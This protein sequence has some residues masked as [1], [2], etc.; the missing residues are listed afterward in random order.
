MASSR[1]FIK[2]LPPTFTDVEFRKHFSQN[3]EITDAK[4]FPNRRIGYIG[5]K[6]PEDA[7]KAVKYFNKTFIRM[8]RIGVELARPPAEGQPRIGDGSERPTARRESLEKDKPEG[9]KERRLSAGEVAEKQDPKLKEF[10]EVM[11]PKS[12]KRAWEDDVA[13][14]TE[15][16]TVQEGNTTINVAA[17]E[18]QSDD[19]YE[20]VP[21]QTKKL[22]KDAAPAEETDRPAE[23]QPTDDNEQDGDNEVTEA[24]AG[25]TQSQQPALSDADWARSRTSRLLGLLDDDEGGT[26]G[27]AQQDR[28][29]SSSDGGAEVQKGESKSAP[30]EDPA[31]SM[32]TPPSDTNEIDA[33]FKTLDGDT[34]AVRSSMR[35]FV[36]NLPYDVKNEDLQAA[37][38]R[39]GHLEEVCLYPLIHINF[40]MN[41]LI[42]TAYA[43]AFDV[44]LGEHFSRCFSCLNQHGWNTILA[45]HSEKCR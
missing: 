14:A 28:E 36:R 43:S 29:D 37:F 40:V 26:V 44:N 21:R 4:I 27:E 35:L 2:G 25:G 15:E 6:T 24:T 10:L 3:R 39:F 17:T 11:R 22:K 20:N 13:K 5:Y 32:P 16:A 33:I 8:S 18:D 12:K 45:R 9:Q 19:E 38:E 41:T 34:D 42:G 30:V 1:I 23:T 31:S 7:Q